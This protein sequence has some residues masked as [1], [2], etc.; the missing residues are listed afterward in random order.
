[1]VGSELYTTVSTVL[2]GVCGVM[3]WEMFFGSYFCFINTQ[4][5]TAL[6]RNSQFEYCCW[7]CGKTIYPSSNGQFQHD[8]A[9][10]QSKNHEVQFSRMAF[11][12]TGSEFKM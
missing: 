12:V 10:S 3:V 1:M 4:N 11:Q 5:Q 7:Q 2:T 6:E 9:L 8:N